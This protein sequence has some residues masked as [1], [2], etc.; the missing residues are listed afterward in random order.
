MSDADLD[1]LT[2][3]EQGPEEK[4][5][6]RR[7]WSNK[8]KFYHEN[9]GDDLIEFQHARYIEG[10]PAIWDAFAGRY[11]IG[12]D[13]WDAAIVD[14]TSG[15]TTRH[16][17]EVTNYLHI[18]APRFDQGDTHL[19]ACANGVIDPWQD[20]YYKLDDDGHSSSFTLNTP[21]LNIPN[22]LPVDWNPYVYDSDTDLALQAFSC[23]DEETRIVL[24][25]IVAACIYR[26]RELQNMAVLIGSGGNGKSVFLHMLFGLLGSE[27][28]SAIDL[29]NVGKRFMQAPLMGRLA[30]IGDDIADGI[31]EAGPLSIVK[32]IVTGDAI[33]SEQKY[34][35]PDTIRPYASLI[36]SANQFP[37]L[38]DYSG[39]MLDRIHGVPFAADFRH[40]P[41]RRVTNISEIL[42]TEE[43]RQYLLNLALGRLPDLVRRGGF[44]PTI[45]AENMREAVL[46]DNDS[47]AYWIDADGIR[48]SHVDGR[49]VSDVY[50]SY[51]TFCENA[52]RK[53]VEQ[54]AF[55]S[56]VNRRLG[57]ITRKDVYSAGRQV[58]GF[59]A[60]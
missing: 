23:G 32:K 14:L 11:R 40:D 7:Y 52:G 53:P 27:N 28:V 3:E 17:A 13:A 4:R 36:F 22:V 54:R 38:A 58:R 21:D 41:E 26:G 31:I 20:D 43:S 34:R 59:H 19:I 39:G 49:A 56:R 44:F 15:T 18:V 12:Y 10:M 47:V 1:G 9:V 57:T 6:N 42:D 55:T 5:S 16:R 2:D 33:S 30:N 29:R 24:E 45:Y 51:R 50:S 37:R 46:N 60:Q 8:G 35:P 48:Q 25:E